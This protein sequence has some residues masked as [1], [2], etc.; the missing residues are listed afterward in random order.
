[1]IGSDGI[2][3]S[4]CRTVSAT[5]AAGVIPS[6]ASVKFRMQIN[7]TNTSVRPYFDDFSAVQTG[8]APPTQI[9]ADY[10]FD[11]TYFN[12][13][14]TLPFANYPATTSFVPDR[15]NIPNNALQV[16][17]N[18]NGT[19]SNLFAPTGA[20]PR[21]ISFWYKTAGHAGFKSLFSYGLANQYQTFGTYFGP[22]G[23]IFLQGFS[24]DHDFEGSYA[25][26][27]WRHLVITFD[28]SDVKLYMNG[29]LVG[30]VA[31]PLLNTGSPLMRYLDPQ[32]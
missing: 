10:T 9:V 26:N 5:L 17:G 28:G 21:T 31:R 22:T 32:F 14:G 3:D 18:D 25:L 29:A 12:T 4:A 30:S 27:T 7:S 8:A 24:Y 6:G 16:L 15:N 11:N 20:S 19:F 1:M 23:N 2:I 13:S